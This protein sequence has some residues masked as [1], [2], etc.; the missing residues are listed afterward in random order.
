VD[1]FA[2]QVDAVARLARVIRL[3]EAVEAIARRKL[4]P[5]SVVM[6][7]DDG[8]ADTATEVLPVLEG[9]DVPATVFIT[10]GS[11]G[12][13]FW[14]DQL[15]EVVVATP[16]LPAR[17]ELE[18]RGNRRSWCLSGGANGGSDSSR[19]RVLLDS[20]AATLR[21]LDS[22][23]RDAAL[24]QL[25]AWSGWTER[26]DSTHRALTSE[27]IRRLAASPLID[28]GA[29]TVS[30]PALTDLPMDGQRGEIARSRG[31][32]TEL[33][34][35]PVT[36]FSYPHGAYAASTI[37]AVQEAGFSV[38]CCS[39]PDVMGYHSSMYAVPR[40]WARAGD[41]ASFERWLERWLVG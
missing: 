7:F 17:L 13:L 40:L 41:A 3:G 34:G 6:T 38:A 36:S 5:R 11:P 30:H 19:R 18:I 9:R 2:A 1:E 10:T 12:R 37:A 14:W 29:H 20:L 26:H 23:E 33:T 39:T 24:S 31:T 27:E 25:R 8:Y 28:I 4:P 35:K 21:P 22:A 32:L 16:S 15:T